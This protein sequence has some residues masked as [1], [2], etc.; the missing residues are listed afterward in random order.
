MKKHVNRYEGSGQLELDASNREMVR[1]VLDEYRDVI[2][3]SSQ[4][5]Q[6]AVSAEKSFACQL[7][8]SKT[9]NLHSLASSVSPKTLHLKDGKKLKVFVTGTSGHAL[10]VTVSGEFF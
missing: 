9:S 8:C 2:A 5:E 4:E 10:S 3:V 6:S 1:Y 7:L